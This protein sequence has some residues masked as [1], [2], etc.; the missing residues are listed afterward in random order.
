MPTFDL[1]LPFVA[2]AV[3]T[4]ATTPL[5]RLAALRLG[6]VS[7]PSSERWSRRPV[8]VLGGVALWAGTLT[9]IVTGPVPGAEIL[10]IL[11]AGSGMFVLGLV[12][13]FARFRPI[14]KLIWQ[15][16]IACGTVV[17]LAP[18]AITGA[19][20]TDALLSIAWITAVTNAFNLLDNMDGLCAGVAAIGALAFAAGLGHQQPALAM[21]ALALA[22]AAVGFLC[23]NFHPATIFMG[24][25]GSLFLGGVLATLTLR[26]GRS[27]TAGLLSAIA[28]PIVLLAI[29]LFDTLF[30]TIVRKLSARAAS[31]G[32]RDHTSHRLVALGFS[33]RRAV[34]LLYGLAATA[35]TSAV[36]LGRAD[37]RQASVIAAV[38]VI[39]LIVLGVRLARVNA[40]GDQEYAALRDRAITPLLNDLTYKRRIFEVLLDSCLI[41]LSYY[42]AY[43][44]RFDDEFGLYY[45]LFVQSLP[46]VLACGLT[47]L[48]VAG[49]YRGFWRY[50]S[51]EDLPT[52]ARGLLAGGLTP[53]FVLVYLYRFEGYPRS[54]FVLHTLILGALMLG[55]RAGF[56]A[57]GDL[58]RRHRASGV[59]AIV[60]GAGDG[61][62]LLVRELRSNGRHDYRL[63]GFVDDDPAK[64]NRRIL[65]VKV[66]G[67]GAALPAVLHTTG[68]QVVIVSTTLSDPARL[69]L[70]A[71][72][73]QTGV[74]V[75]QLEFR[76]APANLESE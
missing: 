8:P 3:A 56:R 28:V 72:S 41:C 4:L 73:G 19:S 2:A 58:A 49:V 35:G 34:L 51:L 71:A 11:G 14:T 75:V 26:A 76:L 27:E 9:V 12:D 74:A 70:K 31:A 53:V 50:I 54:V 45:T 48:Y 6:A 55:S 60:Y 62:A 7:A 64:A 42:T 40:Y 32:G 67:T 63:V 46:V 65:G 47:G 22:G 38:L 10:A 29:P 69:A 18:P 20:A 13:D 17:A 5:V 24:D 21:L 37:L 30:V 68:A 57:L 25:S 39:G 1:M 33:E 36:L 44:I 43:V 59:P 15:V 66:L 16:V 52:Y 61:G 23:F